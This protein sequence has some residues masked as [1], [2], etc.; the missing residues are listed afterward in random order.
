MKVRGSS[1]QRN[2]TRANAKS[3]AQKTRAKS[4]KG[5][6]KKKASSARDRDVFESSKSRKGK[7]I[8]SSAKVIRGTPGDDIIYGG[9]GAQKIIG[10]G[11][12][13]IIIGGGG[14]DKIFG[15]KGNDRIKG[16]AGGDTIHGGK[17][18][19]RIFGGRGNDQ[20]SGDAD[21]DRIAGEIG[22]DHISGGKG[23]D[24][25][26]GGMGI[27]VLHGG[28]GN[29]VQ[30]GDAGPDFIDGGKGN[31]T[32]SFATHSGPGFNPNNPNSGVRVESDKPSKWLS[33]YEGVHYNGSASGG[34]RAQGGSGVDGL[35]GNENVVGSSKD[36]EINGNW[37][38]V[39]GGAGR[40]TTSGN[41]ANPVSASGEPD[42]AVNTRGA[43]VDVTRSKLTGGTSIHIQGGSKN[44]PITVTR[45]GDWIT[46]TSKTGIASRGGG[47]VDGNSVRLHVKGPIDAIS[48]DGGDGNDR[49]Q[50]KGF[51][52]D[53]PIT[54]SGGNGNDHLIGG[55]GN[56]V[57]NDGA[58]NDILEGGGGDDGLTNS[59][60]RDRL[61]GGGGNDL[62]VS[63]SIDKGDLLDG[64]TGLDNVSFAQAGHDFAVRAKVG[65]TAQRIGD[66]GKVSGPKARITRNAEDLEGTE[67]DDVLI[68][69]NKDNKLL[70][71]GG[72]DT[73]LGLGGDD[74]LDAKYKDKDKRLDG[75]P[76]RDRATLDPE[77]RSV[78]R[79]LADDVRKKRRAT[80]HRNIKP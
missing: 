33:D 5:S 31:D 78:V 16:G 46:I 42:K 71:R 59:E 77:D 12:N 35:K 36:D 3:N 29:D 11:G 10:G 18:N 69:D 48:V 73:L 44:D 70:G 2:V 52:A 4:P 54:L 25:A 65:G 79:N 61:R 76:G 41:V 80:H 47:K 40:D 37:K 38:T 30:S 34:D 13:D 50:V 17:D 21:N 67:R 57:L 26:S 14:G 63:S 53:V 60:G 68:G 27:D 45:K 56:D 22:D 66:D 55:K 72:A 8:H 20:L 7:V 43:V 19:D 39:E 51:K 75:G 1:G 24:H 62:L 58:G 9:A 6:A 23:H 15:G 32:V 64:G 49:L 74:R 28:K